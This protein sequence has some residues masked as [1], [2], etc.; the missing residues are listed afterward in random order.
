MPGLRYG[1][2]FT[3]DAE[4]MRTSRLK[5][6]K[7]LKT[8]RGNTAKNKSELKNLNS[9]IKK[10]FGGQGGMNKAAKFSRAQQ[11]YD[12]SGRTKNIAGVAFRGRPPIDKAY[13]KSRRAQKLPTPRK[14]SGTKGKDMS[15][16]IFRNAQAA[17]KA[18]RKAKAAK[19]IKAGKK[20]KAAKK[21]VAKKTKA[22][23]KTAVKKTRAVKKAVVKKTR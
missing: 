17:K 6:L 14:L 18:A 23:K 16:E 12:P 5:L 4:T 2:D 8:K 7:K 11:G 1:P 10:A 3:D 9:Q 22:V 20:V 15:K 21:S 19:K 13:M